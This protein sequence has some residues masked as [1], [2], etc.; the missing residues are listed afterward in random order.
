VFARTSILKSRIGLFAPSGL[1][2]E[3]KFSNIFSPYLHGRKKEVQ[4]SASSVSNRL[5]KRYS[6]VVTL[7]FIVGSI[8]PFDS[9]QGAYAGE[10]EYYYIDTA[11]FESG[12]LSD[13][14]GYLTK[15]N[16]QTNEGDRSGMT[17]KITHTVKPG[18]TLSV[19]AN[20]YGL[21]T[22]TVLWENNL[23]NANSLKVGQKLSI[24]PV[25]GVS[26]KV[27]E[28]ETVDKIA[29]KYSVEAETI[30]KQNRLVAEVSTG[31]SI[32][33]PG[34]KPIEVP[35]TTTSRTGTPTRYNDGTV[36]V[37]PVVDLA[38]SSSVPVGGKPFIRPT[39][40]IITQGYR[41]GHYAI[42]IADSSK[43][44]IWAAGSGTV[45]KASQGTYGG[46]YGN[47]VIID[48]GNGLKTLYAHM[49]YLSVSVGEY[50]EQG[51]VLGRMG[52]T[53]RV[54]GRTGIHLHYEVIQGGV[55]LN[56]SQKT[57]I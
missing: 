11:S 3:Q 20:G 55:K 13:S 26:Y 43:P 27:K 39:R 9:I 7:L 4:E 42:D 30:N 12:I 50:V 48:H 34:A 10:A 46:G 40:G 18:E 41:R 52:N 35:R 17:D 47:H 29:K 49:D 15:V 1:N 31:D 25:D 14:D 51:Q 56:P 53:G 32:F 22:N 36:A 19:I 37:G 54:Y 16:P 23:S 45:V 44:P 2:K 8:T 5:F 21:K 57:S 38:D 33:I 28:G 24:P 6:A